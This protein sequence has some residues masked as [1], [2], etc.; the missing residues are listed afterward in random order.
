MD[1]YFKLIIVLLF[2]MIVLV[3]Y[4]I[5]DFVLK[6]KKFKYPKKT[7]SYEKLKNQSNIL[8]VQVKESNNINDMVTFQLKNNTFNNFI[9]SPNKEN[10]INEYFVT[11]ASFTHI[12]TRN[13]Q[14]DAVHYGTT[15][16]TITNN[17]VYYA[18]LCDGMGGMQNGARASNKA[19]ECVSENYNRHLELDKLP[20][21]L[22]NLAKHTNKTIYEIEDEHGDFG[23]A[24]TTLTSV[25][26]F[27]NKL[28]WVSVGD[29]RIYIIR[30]NEIEQVTN[31][32]NY[33]L[34]LKDQILKGDITYDEAI[35]D[36]NKESLISYLGLDFLEIMDINKNPFILQN[37]DVILLCSDGLTKSLDNLE[38]LS[39]IT[40]SLNNLEE[41][42]RVLTLSAFDKSMSDQ[43]NTSVVL[44]KYN[45]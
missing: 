18:I 33:F 30:K 4:L 7:N 13:Y 37:G 9:V 42:A 16:D 17:T 40:N 14:Q 32:H 41:T 2:F 35:N 8:T 10:N 44:L 3:L 45:K 22:E 23:T 21:Y 26:I 20:M 25:L 31:D 24:G 6:N 12:G 11:S 38:I 43:D 34:T 39:I 36:P 27:L 5:F 28:Y 1:F 29:S 19:I 15:I